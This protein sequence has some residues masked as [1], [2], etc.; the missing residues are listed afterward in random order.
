M[1][2]HQLGKSRTSKSDIF[3]A[4]YRMLKIFM[5]ADTK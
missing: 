3:G 4:T 2:R 5:D 1:S